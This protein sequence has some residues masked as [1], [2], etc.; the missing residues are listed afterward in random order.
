M[1]NLVATLQVL[2]RADS[3]SGTFADAGTYAL[4]GAVAV[5][6]GMARMTI[7]LTVII[8]EATGDVQYVVVALA[9]HP[10]FSRV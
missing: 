1:V 3:F 9:V 2:H 5:L 7:S 10:E 6:G 8:L 4:I